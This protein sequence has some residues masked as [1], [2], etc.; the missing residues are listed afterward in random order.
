MSL[1][2]TDLTSV[3]GLANQVYTWVFKG[4]QSP[5]G[6][7]VARLRTRLIIE[8][9]VHRGAVFGGDL[10]LVRPPYGSKW[11]QDI[12]TKTELQRF[13]EYHEGMAASGNCAATLI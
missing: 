12:P 11:P 5:R 10:A 9:A 8:C 4:R 1:R 2:T 6:Y 13:D 3:E 7:F